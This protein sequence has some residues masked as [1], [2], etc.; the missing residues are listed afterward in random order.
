MYRAYSDHCCIIFINLIL[1]HITL[2]YYIGFYYFYV[3]LTWLFIYFLFFKL[4]LY[5]YML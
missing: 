5:T 1:N 3:F 4:S 2:Y